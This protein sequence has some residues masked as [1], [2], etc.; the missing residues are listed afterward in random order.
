MILAFA[1]SA[2]I[3]N[4][5]GNKPT[6]LIFFTIATLAAVLYIAIPNKSIL[7]ISMLVFAGRLGICPCYSLT[8]ITSN[9]LFPAK[10]KSS[11]FAFCNIIAR[12]L[13]MFAPLVAEMSDPIPFQV[14]GLLAFLCCWSTQFLDFNLM[15]PTSPLSPQK[16]R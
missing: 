7:F 13:C 16:K 14:F 8:F 10:I 12:F 5:L 11:L 6:F 3:I 15:E 1:L 4:R 9:E 2:P